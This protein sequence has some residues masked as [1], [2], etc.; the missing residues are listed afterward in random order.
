MNG[1]G[2]GKGANVGE[3]GQAV[4]TGDGPVKRKQFQ[5]GSRRVLANG[6]D[7]SL[8]PP[9]IGQFKN[10]LPYIFRLV[11]NNSLGT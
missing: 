4:Y 2:F 8:N 1:K 11:I 10:A 6:V 3:I 9:P 5:V 7:D